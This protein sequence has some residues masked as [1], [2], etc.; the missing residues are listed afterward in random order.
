MLELPEALQQ[1]LADR[2]PD[3]M[4]AGRLAQASQACRKLL[5]PRLHVLTEERRLA[6]EQAAQAAQ[7][8]R[9]RKREVILSCFEPLEEG[10][11]VYRCIIHQTAMGATPCRC[12]LR[13][14]PS[15]R[16]MIPVMLN[17]IRHA[18][19]AQ[20]GIMSVLF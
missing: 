5:Q 8:R 4:T 18:H 16:N 7:A 13:F 19:P 11:I 12:T 3:A 15:L 10:A 2:V 1:H 17:H 9:D 6:A 14:Q 20:Y